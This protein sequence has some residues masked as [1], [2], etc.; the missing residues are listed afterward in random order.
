MVI[1]DDEL[2]NIVI[3]AGIISNERLN[4]LMEFTRNSGSSFADALIEEDLV[5]DE[6]LGVLIADY[7]HIPFII[8]SK[9]SIHE[10]VFRLIPERMAR[11]QKIIP[12]EKNQNGLKVAMGNPRNQELLPII[13]KKVNLNI[14][15]YYA[16]DRDI[17]NVLRIY[18]KDLQKT[19]EQLMEQEL[20]TV[21]TQRFAEDAPIEKILNLL[22]ESAY[23]D[24]ASDMHIE[25]EEKET[26][27]RLRID[28]ILHEVLRIPKNIHERLISRIKILSKLRT[29]EHLAPQDGKMRVK[30]QEEDLDIR[31]SI[32]PIADGEKVVLRLLASH[33][34]QFSLVDLGMNERDLKKVTAAYNKSYGMVLSTGPTGS[35][36][37]TCIYSILK[38]LNTRE[39]N[40]TTIEDPIEYRIK[41]VNQ[42]QVNA[43]TNLT[44]ANGLRSILRQDPNVVFVGE[45]RDSE[46]AGIAVNAALTGHLVL[47]TL[48]TND[49]A[50]ALPR[51]IDM[52]IEPFLVASTVNV[53]IAQRL[54]RK[55]CDMCK[56]TFPVSMQE[57]IKN[58]PYEILRRHFGDREEIHVFRG[59]GCKICH[60][61]GYTGR[62]GVF[63]VLEIS[64]EIRRLITQKSDSDVIIKKA[65]EEGM[66]TMLDD[67]LDKASR[68]LTTI[69]EALRVT[70]IESS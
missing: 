39:K 5:S 41:G 7:L 47:S 3:R 23:Q 11:K 60:S 19:F 34:G 49:A 63:E 10:D 13:S 51:L 66:T 24:K 18:K 17:E 40:I 52:S 54:V 28:G 57:L 38:I 70:K 2:K 16:T 20:G 22:L 4:E 65:I 50:T 46:T 59:R 42:I 25:P 15:P 62:I 29:D 45:I 44:F 67:G 12:F 58:I 6:K 31:V 48:H 61:T 53:I 55:I 27:V 35:G 37:T 14:I 68:G 26:I 21:E 1:S 9:L 36:K 32:L 8:L 64:K 56:T 69:E 33:Y 30:M 43:K